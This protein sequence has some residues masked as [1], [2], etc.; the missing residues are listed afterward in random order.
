LDDGGI[1]DIDFD[2]LKTKSAPAPKAQQKPQCK[3]IYYSNLRNSSILN[4]LIN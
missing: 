3:K 4:K 1:F 2:A